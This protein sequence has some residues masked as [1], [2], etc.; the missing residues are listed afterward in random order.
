MD[1]NDIDFFDL[2]STNDDHIDGTK[3][4]SAIECDMRE[5]CCVDNGEI[6]DA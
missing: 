6:S 5:I 2:S 1:N 3:P 4:C